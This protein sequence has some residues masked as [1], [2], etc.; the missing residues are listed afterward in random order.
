MNKSEKCQLDFVLRSFSKVNTKR[1][2]TSH[3]KIAI[4]SVL[5]MNLS[6]SK[7]PEIAKWR[8]KT[9]LTSFMNFTNVMMP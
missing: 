5:K 2:F 4:C 8:K 3:T 9:I 1:N 7:G 6:S